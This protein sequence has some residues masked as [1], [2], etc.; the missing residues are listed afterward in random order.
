ME[1]VPYGGTLAVVLAAA[2]LFFLLGYLVSRLGKNSGQKPGKRGEQF[3]IKGLNYLLSNQTDKA[4]EEFIRATHLDPDTIE[5]Y[6]GLGHLYRSKGDFDRAIR[7]HRSLLARPDLNQK[8]RQQILLALGADYKS[9]GLWGRAV[10]VFR[11]VLKINANK[12]EV[13]QELAAIHEEER[14]W[15]EAFRAQQDYEKKTGSKQKNIL[16]HLQAEIGKE[17]VGRGERDKAHKAFKSALSLDSTCLDAALHW[18][19]LYLEEGKTGKA[20]EIWEGIVLQDS[21]F[22]YLAYRRLEK[23]YF[24]QNRYDDIAKLLEKVVEKNPGNV[25]ARVTLGEYY[26]KRDMAPEALG[27]L[28]EAL[29]VQP[30]S[31]EARRQISQV[32]MRHKMYEEM[33]KE[34]AETVEVLYAPREQYTCTRCG[35]RSRELSWRCPQC[36]GWDTFTIQD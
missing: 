26:A 27:H 4:I 30:R 33:E 11:Q 8:E 9:A 15:K 31:V 19:D 10:D 24:D 7:L 32:L 6:L 35:L 21:P 12:V 22:A 3:Y 36:R 16:A 17:A 5:A 34:F 14:N 18:G 29:A 13:Y 23:A 20:V 1:G 25:M 2:A 28:R